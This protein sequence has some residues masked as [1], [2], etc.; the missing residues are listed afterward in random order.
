VPGDS[1]GHHGHY[2]HDSGDLFPVQFSRKGFPENRYNVPEV[3]DGRRRTRS[4]HIPAHLLAMNPDNALAS[5]WGEGGG[6]SVAVLVGFPKFPMHVEMNCGLALRI[7]FG[8]AGFG[9]KHSCRSLANG[10]LTPG[11][12][13][14]WEDHVNP[15]SSRRL[16]SVPRIIFAVRRSRIT[17]RTNSAD[18]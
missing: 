16:S 3:L 7:N 17:S 15:F 1:S 9:R 18:A 2:F 6:R 14:R 12:S 8:L 10:V 4:D 5:G 13:I 11:A